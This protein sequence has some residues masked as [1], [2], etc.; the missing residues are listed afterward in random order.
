MSTLELELTQYREAI[1]E[2]ERVLDEESA[3]KANRIYDRL[4]EMRQ[5][6]AATEEGRAGIVELMDDDDLSVVLQAATDALFWSPKEAKRVLK[7]IRRRNGAGAL[8]AKYTLEEFE[9]G[10]LRLDR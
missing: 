7:R 2:W 5:S 4:L 1:L 10:G 8:T 6:L 9:A 3:R